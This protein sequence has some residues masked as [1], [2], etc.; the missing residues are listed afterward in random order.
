MRFASRRR[1]STVRRA[2]TLEGAT[3]QVTLGDGRQ[4]AREG[5][6]AVFRA[7][8]LAAR[9]RALTRPARADAGARAEALAASSSSRQGLTI[10]ARNFRT[11]RGEIDL[12]ARDGDTL[13]FVE[14]RLRRPPRSAA[15][16][17]ASPRPSARAWRR[18]G[19]YLATLGREPPCRFDAVLLDALM[20]AASR[21]T[22]HPERLIASVRGRGTVRRLRAHPRRRR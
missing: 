8:Q 19:A 1:S 21:G 15:P 16:R 18:G 5:R 17:R 7:G 20:P 4:F 14:V 22:R 11:R 3:G 2:F 10:V 13:V 12:I 6:L 9:W